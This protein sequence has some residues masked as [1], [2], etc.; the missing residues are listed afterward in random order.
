MNSNKISRILV[1]GNLGYLGRNIQSFFQ[2][3]EEFETF[4]LDYENRD[5][6]DDLVLRSDVVIFANGLSNHELGKKDPHLDFQ[7]NVQDYMTFLSKPSLRNKKLLVLGSLCQYGKLNGLI[8]EYSIQ[9]PIEPQGEN[10]LYIER[11]LPY[12]AKR[13]GF[14][15]I[16]LRL[17]AVV[18]SKSN[19]SNLSLF[20]KIIVDEIHSKP[21]E[22]W[23]GDQ[24]SYSF[25]VVED[26]LKIL[27]QIC[28]LNLFENDAYNL[29]LDG[30]VFSELSLMNIQ[31]IEKNLSE[32]YSIDSS[33]LLDRLG[34]EF[35]RKNI[36]EVI[37][38][39]RNELAKL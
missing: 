21:F 33:K 16:C 5:S 27:L 23:G 14:Y 15:Y 31:I 35:K 10:K 37:G 30:F 38:R 36:T 17:G 8:S 26:F 25:T 22:L 12:L 20:E 9:Q 18:G 29:S 4:G 7:K 19:L 39:L 1:I 6:F 32:S 3:F 28:N 24:R 13:Y 34:M 11:C 2:T